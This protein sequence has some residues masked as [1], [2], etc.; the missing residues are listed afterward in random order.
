M[1][2]AVVVGMVRGLGTFAVAL[3]ALPVVAWF[4]GLRGS[5]TEA[6]SGTISRGPRGALTALATAIKLLEKRAPRTRATDRLLH[7]VAPVLGLIPTVA[8]LAVVPLTTHDPVAAT[9]PVP[10]ALGLLS[11]GA[12]ALAGVGGGNKLALHTA[13]RLV[14]LRLSV[15]AVVAVGALGSALAAGSIDLTEI[16]SAQARPL[17]GAVP[18]WGAFVDVLG[19]AATVLAYAMHAQRVV[20]ARTV[21]SLSEPWHGEAT[22]PVLL[23]H[24]MFESLDLLSGA[25]LIAVL[26]LGGS[27]VPGF[28]DAGAV[29]TVIKLALALALIVVVRNLLPVVTPGVG[30]RLCWTT[31]MPTAALG[32]VVA[33]LWS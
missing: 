22:G 29:V 21:A 33:W 18:R 16:L 14:V 1:D 24:R 7:A 10:L 32:A 17:A 19:F 12:V 9:L 6:A 2:D 15:F 23:G 5:R 8:T 25:A 27:H 26:F 31:L 20:R 3:I 28:G 4:E 30:V 11:T 13:L